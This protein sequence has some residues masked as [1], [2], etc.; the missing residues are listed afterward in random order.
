MHERISANSVCFPGADFPTQAGYWRE[1]DLRRVSLVGSDVLDDFARARA[2][3][4]S[5]AYELETLV[6]GFHM[7]ALDAVEDGWREAR[8]K[9]TRV[10]R[11]GAELGARSIYMVTGGRGRLSWEEAAERFC[12]AIAPCVPIA[13]GAGIELMIENSP[14]VFA[15]V[16]LGL[17]LGDTLSLARMAG[18]GVCLDVFGCWTQAGLRRALE[19]ALPWCHLVQVSDYVYGDLAHGRAVPGEGDIPLARILEW[20]LSAGYAGAFDLELIGRRIDAVGHVEAV[21]RAGEHLSAIL[22]ELGA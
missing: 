6:H 19:G 16:H 1:L 13:K 15:H 18:I 8:E 9:L 22:H 20:L 10:I 11:A 12:E 4:A 5:G 17:S 3:L 21:R 2:A 7:G 14:P